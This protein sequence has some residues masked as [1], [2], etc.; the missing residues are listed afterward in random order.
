MVQILY[1][2]TTKLIIMATVTA[3]IRTTSNRKD[4]YVNL[5]FRLRD[6]R[7]KQLFYKSDVILCTDWWDSAKEKVKAK[8]TC[9]D[10]ERSRIDNKVLELKTLILKI[11]AAQERREDVDSG[12]LS[13]LIDMELHPERYPKKEDRIYQSFD[14]YMADIKP[15]ESYCKSVRL[16]KSCLQRF[17]KYVSIET[18]QEYKLSFEN[19]ILDEFMVF[20]QDEY[21]LFN[22]EGEPLPKYKPIYS[23]LLNNTRM[24]RPKMRGKN[25]ISKMLKVFRSVWYWAIKHQYTDRNPF[26]VFEMP[27]QTYGTPYYITLEERNKI[28]DF[29]LS[30]YPKLAIQ[31]DIFI[32]Q[33][34]IGCRVGDLLKLTPSNVILNTIQYIAQKTVKEKPK[35]I[36]VPLNDRAKEI[37]T[38]YWDGKRQ[39]GKLLPFIKEQKYNVKIKEIFRKCGITRNVAIY[40]STT[41]QE[42]IKPICD[43]ASS[44]L[45][46]RT[47]VGNLYKKV[48]NMDLVASLSGHSSNSSAFYRYRD[49]DLETKKELVDKIE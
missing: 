39:K 27:S 20:L 28:A 7:S 22:I 14:N 17:E 35:T 34:L 31:R 4:I 33:C 11:W 29:D 5:R 36:I 49:I 19:I 46:R 10:E 41:G 32:F 40:N 47:F 45:A 44:H 37:L 48:G 43:I 1:L 15:S 12:L 8:A 25:S 3:F 30:K 16:I 13:R 24:R 38:R 23:E 26:S 2:C 42:E 21:T 6:G 9:S 18:G